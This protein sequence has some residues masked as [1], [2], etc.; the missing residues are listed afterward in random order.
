MKHSQTI[1]ILA[2]IALLGICFLPWSYIASRQITIS[3]FYAAGTHFGKPGLF[4]TA[5]CV[6]MLVLFAVPAVWAKRSN[7]FAA[8]LNLAWSFRNYLLLS[9]CMMGECPEKRPAL[10]GLLL[11]SVIIQVMALLPKFKPGSG[12]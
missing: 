5:M 4:N 12:L 6:I 8:A 3:G 7:V 11:L 1:G 9:S 2:C 10:Y